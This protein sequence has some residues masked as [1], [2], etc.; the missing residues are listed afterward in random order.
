MNKFYI[1]VVMLFATT[2]HAQNKNIDSLKTLT[3]IKI[4]SDKGKFIPG[5]GDYINLKKMNFLNQTDIN[6]VMRNVPGVNI[7]DEE[8]FGLR[9]NI[10]LRGTSV[11]RSAKITLMEDG[12]LMSPAPY[13]DPSAYYFPT[14]ARMQ[15]V[16]VLKG[17]SQIKYG[18]YTIGGAINLLSTAIPNTFKGFAQLSYGS[19][20]TNQQHFWVGDSKKNFDYVFEVNRLASNGF[21]QL[22]NGGNTGFD[23]SDFMGKLRW[24]TI[25][26]SKIPQLVTLKF[27]NTNENANEAYLGLTFEDFKANPLRRY[28][29]T[30]KDNL[31]LNHH[32]LTINHTII[33]YKGLT[34]SSTAYY[35]KT[36]RDW[37][38]V[39]SIDGQSI[40]S[41]LA[42]QNNYL[43]PYQIMIGKADGN[44][45]HQSAARTYFS[46]G[47]QSSI[48]YFF[49][50]NSIKHKIQLGLRLHQDQADR[51]G[52]VSTFSMTNG[53][54]ILSNAGIKGNSENQIRAAQSFAG[55][56]HYDLKYKGLSISPG[57]RFEQIG[58]KFKNYGNNDYARFGSNLKSAKN[59]INILLPG[60][61]IHY[62]IKNDMNIFGG[63]HQGFSPPGMPSVS[64]TTQAKAET[65]VN[66]EIGFRIQKENIKSQIVG[67][68]SD[69]AN[70]LGSDNVSAG[71]IGS[72]DMFNAGN[73]M[74]K[75]TEISFEYNIASLFQ[76]SDEL[77]IPLQLAYTFTQAK[78]AET[79]IN[80]G[81]D[82]GSG[83]INKGDFIPFITPHLLTLSIGFEK[84]KFNINL[85]AKYVGKTRTKPGQNAAIT[86]SSN[87][88]YNDVNA[89]ASFLMID[90]SANYRF[91]KQCTAFAVINN[92]TNNKNII[93]NL[94]QGYRPSLPLSVSAG[95]KL[96]F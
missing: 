50:T 57:I 71:G 30:Q 54:M 65:A 39:N 56:V 53:A 29:A 38:R 77:K 94:P 35:T 47:F 66:Y 44:V 43:I 80:G 52:T 42:N 96:D 10:G 73:A 6:K 41:I 93:A 13:A 58:F 48:Q 36:F 45:S 64:S 2:L 26:N 17:S 19:F 7:R 40:N 76:H 16:E 83:T 78:F 92:L 28:A 84:N 81:G 59:N 75:G 63:V 46:K 24:H 21:K 89:I 9:P 74:I 55:F 72:G 95:L 11:N 15:G 3:E 62:Q 69:Y 37:A 25:E 85:N 34:V 27:L 12:I 8:G 82:W 70:I 33:P 32:H 5:S 22:D 88:N 86:P 60:I 4:V 14:F 51:Y 79:F 18:P 31:I 61:G 67:F 49:E 1:A 23:R 68:L 91:Y 90:V 20:G 87:V